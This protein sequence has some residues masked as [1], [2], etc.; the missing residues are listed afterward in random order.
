MRDLVGVQDKR[1]LGSLHAGN[2]KQLIF[3]KGGQMFPVTAKHFDDQVVL[4]GNH[5]QVA[6]FLHG[7]DL[8]R[9]LFQLTR[10][11]R[12]ADNCRSIKSHAVG[13]EDANYLNSILLKEFRHT[14]AHRPLCDVQSFG[15]LGVAHS[16]IL[17]Q[18]GNN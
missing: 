16:A 6:D 5:Y 17:L 18:E 1:S 4:A 14:I 11:N 3:E 12:N 13:I 7:G 8:F 10:M 15:D 9:R 2:L